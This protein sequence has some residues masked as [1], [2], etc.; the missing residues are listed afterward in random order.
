MIPVVEVSPDEIV[1]YWG[2]KLLMSMMQR[3]SWNEDLNTCRVVGN[4]TKYQLAKERK[5]TSSGR[6]MCHF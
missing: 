6:P 2:R 4:S 5:E 3:L 1:I